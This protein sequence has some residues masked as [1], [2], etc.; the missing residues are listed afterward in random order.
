MSKAHNRPV[1]EIR[2]VGTPL[3]FERAGDSVTFVPFTIKRRHTRR[4]LVPPPGTN[5]SMI[6][7]S[8]DLPMIR[9]IGRAF[10]WQK[11]LDSGEFADATQIAKRYK[12]DHG[13]VCEVLQLTRL[14]PDI[15][16]AIVEGRQPRHLSLQAIRRG[17]PV[18]WEEQCRLLGF[19]AGKG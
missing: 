12:L 6:T 1:T 10:Y 13:W 11:L 8:F 15:L 3:E 19:V 7:P 17:V 5:E 2:D 18:E 14:A 16:A 9:T 4:L